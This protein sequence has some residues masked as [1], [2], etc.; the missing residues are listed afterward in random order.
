[1]FVYPCD[2]VPKWALQFAATALQHKTIPYHI[3]ASPERDQNSKFKVQFLLNAYHFCTIIKLKNSKL[4]HCKSGTLYT[5][6]SVP[7]IPISYQPSLHLISLPGNQLI[8]PYVLSFR[9]SLWINNKYSF[10]FSPFTQKVDCYI[11]YCGVPCLLYCFVTSQ[12]ISS[13]IL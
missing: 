9:I 11:L 1:M 5:P 4:N 12:Y 10:L 2:H 6:K 13:F 8:I 7:A 3:T